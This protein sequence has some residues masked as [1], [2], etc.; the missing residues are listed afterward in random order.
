MPSGESSLKFR[1]EPLAKQHDRTAFSCGVKALDQYL[2]RQA[3]QDVK[4]HV[5]VVFVLTPDGATIAG[6]YTLSQFAVELDVIP[7][8]IAR[9]LPKFPQ[10]PATLLG[11]LA[12]DANFHGRGLGET[13]LMD[14]LYRCL[15]GSRQLGSAA[16]IV[17]AKDQ[18]AVA[19]YRKYGFLELPKVAHRLFL[20]MGTIEQMFG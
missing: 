15:I 14:A 5:A 12:V 13:L 8:E 7:E 16:V 9:K 1:L 6:F 20:P 18:T 4:K 10:V 11:R 2:Q 17:D 3:T 19:F